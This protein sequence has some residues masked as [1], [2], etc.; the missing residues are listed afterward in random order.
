M[1]KDALLFEDYAL[2]ELYLRNMF[3]LPFS[4][5][6]SVYFFPALEYPGFSFNPSPPNLENVAAIGLNNVPEIS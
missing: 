3:S 6:Y 4:E 5:L 1:L 2:N